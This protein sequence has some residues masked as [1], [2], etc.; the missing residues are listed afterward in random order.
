MRSVFVYDFDVKLCYSVSKT[1]TCIYC[2]FSFFA[3]LATKR[4]GADSFGLFSGD[5]GS[6]IIE[7]FLF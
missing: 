3:V 1:N 5:H 7:M 4:P 6:P 2:Y